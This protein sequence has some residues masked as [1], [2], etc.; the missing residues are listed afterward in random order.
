MLKFASSQKPQNTPSSWWTA[1][2]IAFIV[3]LSLGWIPLQMK[4]PPPSPPKISLRI[5]SAS[6]HSQKPQ[7]R[8]KIQPSPQKIQ[9]PKTKR[10]RR[11]KR[12][13]RIVRSKTFPKP[14]QRQTKSKKKQLLPQKAHRR[15]AMAPA[16]Q[17]PSIPSPVIPAEKSMEPT[18][19]KENEPK[20]SKS[21]LPQPSQPKPS[22]TQEHVQK[23]KSFDLSAYRKGLLPS[24][25]QQKRYPLMAQRMG[26]EGKVVVQINVHPSGKLAQKPRVLRSSGYQVLD[27]EALRMI[28]AAA[29]FSP[30][31]S[32]FQGNVARFPIPIR[33]VLEN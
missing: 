32:S 17:Q 6:T 8:K 10:R 25:R 19:S 13:K 18:P 28:R 20:E 24:I 31:P 5:L 16:I 9:R 4:T 11:K 15:V 1:L 3:H 2:G 7:T 29:P 14:V 21:I 30:L 26:F 27:R 33:F 22:P 12:R 23:R